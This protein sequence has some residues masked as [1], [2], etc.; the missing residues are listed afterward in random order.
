M[1]NQDQQEYPFYM[2]NDGKKPTR[3]VDE[4]GILSEGKHLFYATK[5]GAYKEAFRRA[6]KQY[7]ANPCLSKSH[8]YFLSDEIPRRVTMFHCYGSFY[9]DSIRPLIRNCVGYIKYRLGYFNETM[10]DTK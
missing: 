3:S 8:F 7:K 1:M 9:K 4:H 5:D 10:G 6:K 2:T